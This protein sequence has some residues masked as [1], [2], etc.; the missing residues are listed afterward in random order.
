M[1]W[2]E[3]TG[4]L[5]V[6]GWG[7]VADGRVR[8]RHADQDFSPRPWGVTQF[9]KSFGPVAGQEIPLDAEIA[10]CFFTK[11]VYVHEVPTVELLPPYARCIFVGVLYTRVES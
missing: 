10:G 7:A 2:F 1:F 6:L 4:T 11:C 8:R 9:T 3:V 5:W